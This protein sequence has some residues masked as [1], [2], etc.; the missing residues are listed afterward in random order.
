MT[1]DDGAQAFP[2]RTVRPHTPGMTSRVGALVSSVLLVLGLGLTVVTAAPAQAA[3]T[4]TLGL[5]AASGLHVVD[6]R[7]QTSAV[8]IGWSSSRSSVWFTS[9]SGF[10]SWPSSCQS[11]DEV[12]L[13][14][15]VYCPG[16]SVAG[17]VGLFGAGPD[18][19]RLSGVCT[20]YVGA[21]LGDGSDTFDF[22]DCSTASSEVLGEG[23]DDWIRTGDGADSVDAGAGNDDVR[24]SG[25]DDTVVLGEGNDLVHTSLGNDTIGGGPGNDTLRPGPGNDTVNGDDVDDLLQSLPAAADADTGADD[26]RGGAGTDTLDL[27][28]HAPG[29][30]VVLDDV[31]NDGGSGEGDNY[32]SDLER[33]IGTSGADTIVGT[34][35]PDYLRGGSGND[36]VRGLGGNDEIDADS[37][38]DVVDGGAGDDALYGGYGDDDVTGGPGADSLY[39]DYTACSAYACPAGADVLRAVDGAVDTVNCGSGADQALVDSTDVLGADGFQVCESVQRT[40]VPGTPQQPG[41]APAGVAL[42]PGRASRNTGVRATLSCATACTATARLTVSPTVRKALR[43]RGSVLGTARVSV[44]A[45]RSTQFTVRLRGSVRRALARAG[46]VKAVLTVSVTSGS[47]TT[48]SRQVRI[49]R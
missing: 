37:D 26:L 6:A 29:V 21:A 25:G 39:G 23:G 17:V 8:N 16:S 41:S 44:A 22:T 7:A 12:P 5:D 4:T 36:T 31:A 19:L 42:E 11:V 9:T 1:R 43:L 24:T 27:A 45:G 15:Y 30:S 32:H 40:A 10:A 46:T 2:G 3:A 28:D 48:I 47:T 33:I 49:T 35:R 13:G 18:T 20:D 14:Q 38:N 34:D